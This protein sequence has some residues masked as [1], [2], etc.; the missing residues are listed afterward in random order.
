MKDNK[1]K[2]HKST[3]PGTI[4]NNG[5]ELGLIHIHENVIASAVRKASSM[6]NWKRPLTKSSAL[7][8]LKK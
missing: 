5:M 2:T 1:K 3:V 7:Y 8:S 6:R 4:S